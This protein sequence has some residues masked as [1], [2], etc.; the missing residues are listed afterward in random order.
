MREKKET[1]NAHTDLEKQIV[2]QVRTGLGDAIR[3]RIT[4]GY[5]DNPLNKLIDSVVTDR[6][7][8]IRAIIEEAIDSSLV[9]DFRKEIKDACAHKLA[10]VLVSKME[11]EIEKRANELRTSPELRARITLA[12]EHAIKGLPCSPKGSNER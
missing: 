5:H 8:R 2:E 3:Q 1:M 7:P 11:G 10:R 6:L 12:I 4:Q 9:E